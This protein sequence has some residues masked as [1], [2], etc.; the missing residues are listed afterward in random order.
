GIP[1]LQ[2]STEISFPSFVEVGQETEFIVQ[3]GRT[4]LVE[5]DMDAKPGTGWIFLQAAP[6]Q[7]RV[8]D[9]VF[10]AGHGRQKLDEAT[11]MNDVV[12]ELRS[13][14]ELCA[15]CCPAHNSARL[16]SSITTSF[17]RV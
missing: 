6:L 9:Q 10:H 11:R 2:G 1:Q 17:I 5:V 7:C 8:G 14:A 4:M 16:R 15:G 3:K 12:I 13:R